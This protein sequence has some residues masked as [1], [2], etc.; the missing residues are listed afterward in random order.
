MATSSRCTPHDNT[1][2]KQQHNST[3]TLLSHMIQP[4]RHRCLTHWHSY[5]SRSALHGMLTCL[6]VYGCARSAL[7][8]TRHMLAQTQAK[9][10]ILLST[11]IC[12]LCHQCTPTEPPCIMHDGHPPRC[13][14]QLHTQVAATVAAWRGHLAGKRITQLL[15]IA[16]KSQ[17]RTA[18]RARETQS[19]AG[20]GFGERHS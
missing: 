3:G 1:R 8:N 18:P 17:K 13:M 11:S 9:A 12:Y 16:A 20:H 7:Q 14:S 10:E 4:S 2:T 15:H 5:L 19:A 6:Y